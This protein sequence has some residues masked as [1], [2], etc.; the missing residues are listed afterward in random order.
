MLR[1]RVRNLWRV[2]VDHR[3]LERE[4]TLPTL[5]NR[6][7]RVVDVGETP[8]LD[9]FD[10]GPELLGR[11]FRRA[12]RDC[13][14]GPMPPQDAWAQR[15]PPDRVL[16]EQPQTTNAVSGADATLTGFGCFPR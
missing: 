6:Q 1:P 9:V 12:K 10:I 13:E 2:E 14:Q 11:G 3:I 15:R 8:N 5:G 7:D 16:F 4:H